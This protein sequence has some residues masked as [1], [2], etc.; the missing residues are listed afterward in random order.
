VVFRWEESLW[1]ADGKTEEMESQVMAVVGAVC[2]Q[3]KG[4]Q[5][6]ILMRIGVAY[7]L[8]L[9]L[10]WLCQQPVSTPQSREGEGEEQHTLCCLHLLQY[11]CHI[12]SHLLKLAHSTCT[13]Y[14]RLGRSSMNT[15]MIPACPSLLQ[16]S[17]SVH[18][19]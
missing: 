6:A 16:P 5:R 2:S 8:V 7:I 10:T 17:A 18:L 11:Q 14:A 1:A 4:W 13:E 9:H 12:H 3:V 15:C 19:P